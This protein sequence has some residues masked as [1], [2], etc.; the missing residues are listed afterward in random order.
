MKRHIILTAAFYLLCMLTA[1]GQ[2]QPPVM[3]VEIEAQPKT[4][5]EAFSSRPGIVIVRGFSSVARLAGTG[6]T[7]AV[8]AREL[9][10]APAGRKVWGLVI[11][12]K[13]SGPDARAQ[14]AFV[15]YDEI[16]SLLKGLDY[17]GK[18][19]KSVTKLESFQ[20]DYRTRGNLVVSV[21]N[22]GD[23]INF[24]VWCGLAPDAV[25]FKQG[26]LADFRKAVAA[27]KAQLDAVK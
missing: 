11:E 14:Q 19:D 4:A 16:E 7:V 3:K 27:A 10:N 17:L 22:E 21:F 25:Y 6:G 24:G 1:T 26:G 5:L 23:A 9:A 20:A 18:M 15:D 12:T 13:A 2:T 8:E